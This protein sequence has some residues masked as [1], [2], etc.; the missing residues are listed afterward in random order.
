MCLAKVAGGCVGGLICSQHQMPAGAH[1]G[2]GPVFSIFL[3]LLLLFVHTEQALKS[4]CF[5]SHSF[6]PEG[7]LIPISDNGPQS[8]IIYSC[9][10]VNNKT[11]QNKKNDRNR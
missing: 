8:L 10:P 5:E 2:K 6:A 3:P 11:K 7:L 1:Q 4:W 9:P